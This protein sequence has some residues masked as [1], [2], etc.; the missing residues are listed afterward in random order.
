MGGPPRGRPAAALQPVEDAWKP[1]LPL[2]AGVP[3]WV[4]ARIGRAVDRGVGVRDKRA[5]PDGRRGLAGP[6][7]AA[8][9]PARTVPTQGLPGGAVGPSLQE[10][11][12]YSEPRAED[13][14][15]AGAESRSRS[16]TPPPSSGRGGGPH[17]VP[18]PGSA[19]PATA[20]LGL[21]GFPGA[22]VRLAFSAAFLVK[23]PNRHQACLRNDRCISVRSAFRLSAGN[24]C[25]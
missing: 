16:A 2:Q 5:L 12:T 10:K 15:P 19:P 14:S 21:V 11:R 13:L 8:G 17:A 18:V 23:A 24:H 1:A 22:H 7:L 6:V 9:S 20:R 4:W 25:L 3:A